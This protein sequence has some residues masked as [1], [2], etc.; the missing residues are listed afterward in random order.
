YAGEPAEVGTQLL[1]NAALA[2][3]L[4]AVLEEKVNLVNAGSAATARGISVEERTRRRE[5]GFPNTIEV[6]VSTGSSN[7]DRRELSIEGT[8]L[9]DAAPRVLRFDGIELEAPL[10]PGTLLLTRNRDVPGV[11]GQIG[12]ALGNLGINIA[13]FALGRRSPER[14][15]DA[16][17]LV[18][19]DGEVPDSVAEAIRKIPAITEARLIRL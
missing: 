15:A 16:M 12:T 11:I 8:A 10:D 19:L 1:R 17:A 2:G 13:T 4:N 9:H 6:L 7:A 5:F 18:R 3:L 14:G